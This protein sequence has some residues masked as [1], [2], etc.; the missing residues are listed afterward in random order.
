MVVSWTGELD[1]VKDLGEGIPVDSDGAVEVGQDDLI[2]SSTGQSEGSERRRGS[3]GQVSTDNGHD[4][5]GDTSRLTDD[6]MTG[7]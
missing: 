3:V 2:Y 1:T 5:K 6:T 4:V 7:C